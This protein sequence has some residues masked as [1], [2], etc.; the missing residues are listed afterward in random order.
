M[1]CFYSWLFSYFLLH[2]G[3][4]ILLGPSQT[5]C[6]VFGPRQGKLRATNR[7]TKTLKKPPLRLSSVLVEEATLLLC[8][9]CSSDS[10]HFFDWNYMFCTSIT[11]CVRKHNRNKISSNHSPNCIKYPF[12]IKQQNTWSMDSRGYRSRQETGGLKNPVSCLNL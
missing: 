10:A 12:I 9:I 3:F 1:F 2:R 6:K 8:S 7:K 11:S 5:S 4:G